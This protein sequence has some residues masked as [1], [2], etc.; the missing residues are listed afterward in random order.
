MEWRQ[1]PAMLLHGLHHAQRRAFAEERA[2]RGVEEL[3][4][5]FI[6]LL[7]RRGEEEGEE[8]SQRELADRLRLAPATVAVALK[9][10]E[11]QGYVE[12][13][14]HERDARRNRVALTEKGRRGIELSGQ[15]FRAVEARMLAGFT[16]EERER[17]VAYQLRMLENLGGLEPAPFCRPKECEH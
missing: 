15:A 1:E 11:R 4:S 5:P 7:L 6:L 2:A 17:L 9:S 12:R 14:V 10:L 8:Y 16:A 13:R 3:G